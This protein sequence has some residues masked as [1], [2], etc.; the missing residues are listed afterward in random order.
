[1]RTIKK[2]FFNRLVAQA[3]EAEIQGLNKVAEALTTQISKNASNIRQDKAIYHYAELEFVKDIQEKLWDNIIRTADFYNVHIDAL[4]MQEIVDRYAADMVNEVRNKLGVNHG[5][6]AY[7]EPVPG[8]EFQQI[9][10]EIS[11]KE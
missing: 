4:E 7:E 10:I 8:E 1:M 11:D 3:E 5:I 6:G 2:N 9:K